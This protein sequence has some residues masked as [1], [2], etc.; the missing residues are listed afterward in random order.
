M[1]YFLLLQTNSAQSNNPS[2]FKTGGYVFFPGKSMVGESFT[3]LIPLHI[4]G[5]VQIEGNKL[6]QNRYYHIP[7]I[8]HIEVSEGAK[9]VALIIDSE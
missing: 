1:W 3:M 2:K 4:A 8:C 5:N 6:D 7:K 9:L